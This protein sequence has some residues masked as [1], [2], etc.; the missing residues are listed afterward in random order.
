MD[1]LV[2]R[3]PPNWTAVGFFALLGGMHLVLATLAFGGGRWE[4]YLSLMLGTVFVAAAALAIGF[5]FEVAV[6]PSARLVRLRHGV[7]RL[8]VEQF[9][10]F[11]AV[12]GVR[13]T[14]SEASE[15]APAGEE[16]EAPAPWRRRREGWRR[17]RG[18][19]PESRL[20]LLCPYDAI[21]CPQTPI[22]RQE[23]L[24]LAMA[25]NVPLVKVSPGPAAEEPEGP[26]GLGAREPWSEGVPSRRDRFG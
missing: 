10:P 22:P 8:C 15:P 26:G 17:R 6:L 5:R 23:A 16:V 25:M 19:Y 21:E 18:M 13:L 20:E 11:A 24:Y 7:G 3:T 12:R 9:V 14:L 2:L 4:G 1:D